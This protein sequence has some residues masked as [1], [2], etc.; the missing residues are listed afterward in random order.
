[1]VVVEVHPSV[2]NG[3]NFFELVTFIR[4][5]GDVVFGPSFSFVVIKSD[6]RYLSTILYMNDY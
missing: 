2:H 4:N 5:L 1:M 3:Q 6:Y